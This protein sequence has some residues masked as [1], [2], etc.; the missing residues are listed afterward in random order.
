MEKKIT[1]LDG[2][3]QEIEII[4]TKDELQPYYDQAYKEAQPHINLQG[5]RKGKVPINMVRKIYGRQLEIEKQQDI[6]SEVFTKI[7]IDE[8]IPALG[9]PKLTDIKE[10]ETGLEFKL[11]Y[12]IIPN[13]ELIDYKELEID[14]PVHPVSDEEIEDHITK[15][16]THNGT[17]EEANQVLDNQ[18]VVGVRLRE[19]DEETKAPVADVDPEETHVYLA[20]DKVL[21]SLKANL[22]N[23]K[24]ADKFQYRPKDEDEFAPDK[25]YD[26]EVFDIQKLIPAE[27]NNAFVAT[28]T[29]GKFETTEE[30]REEIGF[31]LQEAWDEESR[32]MME[33]QIVDKL[34]DSHEFP[35]PGSVVE[36]VIES[37]VEDLK[38]KYKDVPNIA[39]LNPANMRNDLL[40]VAERTVKWEILRNKIIEKE[41]LQVED[42]DLD[43]IVESEAQRLK[44]DKESIKANLMK[45]N[46]FISAVLGKKVM[47][48][49][50]D[51]ATTNEISFEEYK[52]KHEHDGH[53]HSEHDHDHEGHDHDHD[54]HDHDHDVHDHDHDGHDHDHDGHDHH[55]HSHKH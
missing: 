51:F 6:I 36:K 16:I 38:K 1:P 23:A 35:L 19:F 41:A 44:S 45:N 40:P 32:K 17:F 50:K 25:T 46:N 30:Y 42:H 12:E 27:F 5:F 28:Y 29:K 47:D 20:D 15:L 49:L 53:N 3:E 48:L 34:V 22:M 8:K 4:L 37:M 24:I 7:V 21:P 26:V 13:F 11:V 2:C 33:E 10:T 54:E 55:D 52:I 9:D 39:N 18:F 14:E 43:G 31:K